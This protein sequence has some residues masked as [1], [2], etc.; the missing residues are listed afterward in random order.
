VIEK[1]VVG[2]EGEPEPGGHIPAARQ[3]ASTAQEAAVA[4]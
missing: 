4:V 1:G 2:I 3:E